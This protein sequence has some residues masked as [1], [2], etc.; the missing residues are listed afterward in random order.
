MPQTQ[1]AGT[2]LRLTEN[3][4]VREPRHSFSRAVSPERKDSTK[5][6]SDHYTEILF[7]YELQL[8]NTLFSQQTLE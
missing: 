8:S 3:V 5:P 6:S 1:V 2:P 4:T 7:L